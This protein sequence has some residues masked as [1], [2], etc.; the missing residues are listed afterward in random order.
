VLGVTSERA[1]I[2]LDTAEKCI[3]TGRLGSPCGTEHLMNVRR[4]CIAAVV[5]PAYLYPRLALFSLIIIGATWRRYE[6]NI[7]SA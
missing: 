4:A 6:V 7:R 2:C 3:Y 5:T 1:Q